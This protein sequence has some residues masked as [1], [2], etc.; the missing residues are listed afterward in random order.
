MAV[1]PLT[2]TNSDAMRFPNVIV[3]VLSRIIVSISPAAST[4]LPD[5]ARTLY[6]VT[7]SIPA[8]PMADKSPPMVV[9]MRQ[10]SSAIKVE[11]SSFTPRY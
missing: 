10:T 6:C 9:G 7:R 1:T 8:I 11:I 4:A 5:I 3:P 2:G